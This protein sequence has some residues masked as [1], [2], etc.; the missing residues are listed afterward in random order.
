M[1]C[2]VLYGSGGFEAR[3]LE[4]R[5]RV[6]EEIIVALGRPEDEIKKCGCGVQGNRKRLLSE[7]VSNLKTL[8]QE[9]MYPYG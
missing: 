2:C 8:P 6:A 3:S 5:V 9:S 1:F 7:C 4:S